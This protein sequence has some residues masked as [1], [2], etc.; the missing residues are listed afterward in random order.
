MNA[1]RKP[2]RRAH[3]GL[4]CRLDDAGAPDLLVTALGPVRTP[5]EQ[6]RYSPGTDQ[7]TPRSGR[8]IRNYFVQHLD[9]PHAR[10]LDTRPSPNPPTGWCSWGYYCRDITPGEVLA[11]ARW[12]AENMR[13]YGWNLVLLDDGWQANGR[14]WSGLRET[15]PRGMKWLAD[16]IKKLGLIPG[17]WLCPHGQDNAE[18]VRSSGCFLLKPDG[19]SVTGTFCGPYTVD[20]SKPETF[21]YLRELSR[22]VTRDWGYGYLKLDGIP[23]LEEAYRQHQKAFAD[24]SKPWVAALR[25]TYQALRA[26]AGKNVFLAGCSGLPLTPAGIFNA[27]RTGSDVDAEWRAFANAVDATMRG[28][29]LN[30]IVWHSDPDYGLL[31]SPLTFGMAQAWVTLLGLTG[32]HQLFGDR[33]PDLAPDRVRLMKKVSPP[34]PIMPFDLFPAQ[35]QKSTFALKINRLG[36]AY[37]V[38]GVFNYDESKQRVAR[39]DFQQLGLD[40]A[41]RHHVYDFWNEDYLGLCEAGV[42]LEVPPAACRVVTLYPEDALPVLLS[43][44]RHITQGWPDLEQFSVN[45]RA[46]VLKGAS[47]VIAGEPYTLTFG[48]PNDGAHTFVL[49]R[50][51]VGGKPPV[52]VTQGRGVARATWTPAATECVEWE[53][54]F[55]RQ[56]IVLPLQLGSYP[57]MLGAR[58][59]DPWTVEVFWVSFGSPAGFHVR[60][61]G[62]QIGQTFATR[63]RV[64]GLKYGSRHT[65]EIGV[66]DRDGRQGARTGR[67]DV[68]VGATLPNVLHLS[69]L[70]WTSAT[71]GYLHAKAD[72]SVGGAG[73]SVGGRRYAKGIGTHPSSRIVYDLKGLFTRLRGAY[74]IEDQNGIP[75][76]KPHAQSGQARFAIR[77]DGRELLPWARRVH[78]QRA[79]PFALDVRGVRKLELCVEPPEGVA[80]NLAPHANWL[81][82]NVSW[83]GG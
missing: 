67:I 25:D 76:D 9:V 28:L 73:L 36:R 33:L 1:D 83:G 66:A 16:E 10:P 44:S 3:S 52:V 31:R 18:L 12:I 60:Q 81:D 65:F 71:S 79:V 38:V 63:F 43:T 29:H 49:S 42:F 11:N 54:R 32:Q 17:I 40:P 35:R 39:L 47:R 20:P 57:Y 41:R 78:G 51:R 27:Q 37:D 8:I 6:A 46:T 7:V 45:R 2:A 22:T 75:A 53:A 13:E 21:R 55:R 69:D 62:R 68:V 48:L 70:A 82:L 56:K 58:D 30:R 19:K 59:L 14:D 5:L 15:F 4:P 34:A 24:P 72:K 74:G 23:S 50:I 80:V 61:N 77:A 26:G 64:G